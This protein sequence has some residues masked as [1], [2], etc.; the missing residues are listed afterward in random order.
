MPSFRLRRK[1]PLEPNVQL[2][3]MHGDERADSTVD[4]V[5]FEPGKNKKYLCSVEVGNLPPTEAMH[6]LK[7][8]I[9]TLKEFFGD[10]VMVIPSRDGHPSMGIYEVEEV[11]DAD[12]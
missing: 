9:K 3:I 6:Y 12:T 2:D 7:A 5:E 8:A 4:L 1:Q 11:P 10:N